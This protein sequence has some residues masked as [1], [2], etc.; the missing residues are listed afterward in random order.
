MKNIWHGT[1]R[2]SRRP[3]GRRRLMAGAGVASLIV[4][5]GCAS[6][7]GPAR[8]A[9]AKVIEIAI[10]GPFT[11]ADALDGQEIYQGASLATD[12]VNAAGGI[13]RGP[14]KGARISL[15]K[16]DDQ[17]DPQ[18]GVIVARSAIGN[19]SILAYVGSAL[20]DVSVAQAPF[21]ERASMPFVSVY[22]SANTI[23]QPAKHYVFVVPPTF[24]AY[25][26]SIADTISADHIHSVGVIHLTGTYGELIAQYLVQR[27]QQLGVQVTADEAFNI[28]DTDFRAQLARIKAGN[29]QAVAMVGLTDS[30]TLILKQASELGLHVPFFDPGGIDFSEAFL[31]AAGT[32]ANGVTGNTPTDPNRKT[33]AT[34]RLVAAWKSRYGTSIVPDP[35]AFAWA[36][37]QAVVSAIGAG[38]TTRES[39]AQELHSV[40]IPDTSTGPLSFAPDGAR[41]GARLWIYRIDNGAFK[42]FTGYE[43]KAVF[44]VVA[45]PLEE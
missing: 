4:A 6:A 18:T 16:F 20:S 32:L 42:F 23:L 31:N 26:Y 19:S 30:D 24:D 9:D 1:W 27:L 45:I 28:G 44:D 7:G 17:D 11:G 38:G 2:R 8:P 13:P 10:G 39:L 14:L 3:F 37:M 40:Y 41:I 33:P 43:Q 21:F 15:V 5:A 35:G 36:A 25:S 29:P 12:T 34:R 22:A